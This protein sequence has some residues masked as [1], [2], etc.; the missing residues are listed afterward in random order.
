M[1]HGADWGGAAFWLFI[2]ACVIAGAWERNRRETERH[3]TLR[4]LVEKTGNLDEAKLK[5]LFSSSRISGFEHAPGSGYRALRIMGTLIMSI[6]AALAVFFT[7]M[8]YTAAV[9]QKSMHIGLS[10]A[11]AIVF[12]GMA[13]FLSSRYAA[14]PPDPGNGSK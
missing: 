6:G 12:V 10:A 4:L 3:K 9:E 14:R 11:C 7:I 5:E 8:G 2:G 13:M 1:A